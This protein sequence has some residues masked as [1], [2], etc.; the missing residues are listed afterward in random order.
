MEIKNNKVYLVYQITNLL[1]G[2]IYIGAHSTDN[3]NDRYM[4]SSRYL[5]K[6]IK[7]F[8]KKNFKKEILFIFN[9]KEEMLLKEAEL[10]NKEFVF[11]EDTYNKIIGGLDSFT[12]IG[13]VTVKDK[14]GNTFL[15][16]KDDPKYISGEY[17]F[18]ITG[19]V[20]A[21]DKNGDIIQVNKEDE[22]IK[23][24]ELI[25][26]N[27]LNKKFGSDNPSWKGGPPPKKGRKKRN[28]PDGKWTKKY[29]ACI[30]CNS[31][32]RK[33][34][35]KGLCTKCMMYKREINDRGY[36]CEYDENGKRIFS[37]AHRNN[38]SKSAIGN[39]NGIPR[40]KKIKNSF[41]K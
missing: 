17:V 26:L 25:T 9:N 32:E 19:K 1:N 34:A 37:E 15:A 10:V 31:S 13:M 27:A 14:Y 11:R 6:D 28:L 30:S 22:R 3:I 24:W 2:H 33:H 23:S 35:G 21:K 20:L 38:L 5:R 36:E 16:Y 4:G 41:N 18:I 29:D 40:S 7:E 8:G 12:T 39:K